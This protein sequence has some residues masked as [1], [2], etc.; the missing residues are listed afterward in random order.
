MNP[1]V[2]IVGCPRSGTTLLQRI[3]N[4]HPEIAVA[5]ESHWIPRLYAKPWAATERGMISRKLVTRLL[6][7]PKF[8][9]LN[10]GSDDVAELAEKAERSTYSELVSAIFDLY[11]TA[12]GKPLVGDKTPDYVRAIDILHRLWPSARFVH[13]IRDGRDVALSMLDWPKVDPKPGRFATWNREKILTAAA[14]WELNVRLGRRAGNSLGSH[15]YREVQYELLVNSPETECR[16]LCE[17]L[18]VDFDESILRF[19][20]SPADRDPGVDKTRAGLPL[21][22]GLRSWQQQMR[23]EDL[24]SFEAAAGELLEEVGYPRGSTRLHPQLLEN[25]VSVRASLLSDPA[26][27]D[28]A[29]VTAS[30]PLGVGGSR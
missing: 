25:A 8:R 27:R 6:A 4:S 26:L 15:L 30:A 11:G 5:P 24:E 9:R 10:L 12:Q 2:F 13:V 23:A 17:F 29:W 21:T 3:V 14:W 7:H 20:D 1:Y 22:V 16:A 18:A 19:H 28:E